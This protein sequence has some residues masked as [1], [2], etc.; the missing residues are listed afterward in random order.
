[1]YNPKYF[2][3]QDEKVLLQFVHDH[4]FAFLTGSSLSGAQVATQI[5]ILLEERKG[6]KYLYGHIMRQTDHYRTFAE[7]PEVLAVFTGAHSYVSASWYSN[8]ISGSTWNY[9]SVHMKG[10]MR[11]LSL[12]ELKAFMQ[13]L[14]LHFEKNQAESPTVFDNLP[15]EYQNKM[16]PHIAGF[17]I[18]V[19]AME[20]IFKL[21]QNRDEDS[22]QNIISQLREQGG[23]SA[24][25]A[26]EM[27]KRLDILFPKGS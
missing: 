7:N 4:P 25:I 19:D 8:P 14:S 6:E 13:K 20:N 22:F 12:D 26:D 15:V 9:M 18:K 27:L 16:L 10:K 24:E 11:F 17:E 21:S 3:E 23:H 5:P 2:T 1:M